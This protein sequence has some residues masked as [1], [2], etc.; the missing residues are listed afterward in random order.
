[1]KDEKTYEEEED[2]E[3]KAHQK[4]KDFLE[5]T[6]AVVWLAISSI[7]VWVLYLWHLTSRS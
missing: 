7:F 4:L 5:V 2:E 3:E 6:N 1:M